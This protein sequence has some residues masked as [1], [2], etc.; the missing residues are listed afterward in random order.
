MIQKF[1]KIQQYFSHD[2]WHISTDDMPRRKTGII[3]A[4]R[5]FLLSVKGYMADKVG[6]RASAL[7][8][9]TLLSIVPV[10]AMVFGIAKGFGAKDVLQGQLED[11]LEGHEEVF[12]WIVTF[13]ESMLENTKGGWMAGVGIVLLM[14]SVFKILWNIEKSFN[15]IWYIEKERTHIRKLSDYLS[16]VIISPLLIILSGSMNIFIS[17]TL[18]KL[19]QEMDLLETIGPFI[20][21]LLKFSPYVMIWLLLTL[22]YMVM[23]NTNVK[24]KSALVAGIIAGTIFQLVQEAYIHFQIGVSSYN[25]IYGS[26]AAF[27]MFLVFLQIAWMIVLF[28]AE[29]SYAH[30]NVS[31]YEFEEDI[32]KMS[33]HGRKLACL[34]VLHTIIKSFERG[35]KPLSARDITLHYHAPI[36]LTDKIIEELLES[37]L[38]V[39]TVDGKTKAYVPATDINKIDIDFVL[40]ALSDHGAEDVRIEKNEP[41][42]S[43]VKKLE[44]IRK[45]RKSSKANV[46]L[47]DISEG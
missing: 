25:A 1:Q 45:D 9:F 18:S 2:I 19:T 29:I 3:R 26:F 41:M 32:E 7:T 46:M 6:V 38:I 17:T 11:S 14:W 21:F 24:F 27:P 39:E 23:P 47:K 16:I 37:K 35:E 28:G 5:V 8:F 43:F 31:Q 15:H 10:L 36:K 33:L 12:N 34:T 20:L 22:L 4:L 44:T 30:Q 13:S 42:A 40:S